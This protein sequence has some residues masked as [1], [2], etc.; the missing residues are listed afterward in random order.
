MRYLIS[1]RYVGC[2]ISLIVLQVVLLFFS[3]KNQIE[4]N[5]VETDRNAEL[6]I[7]SS[8][9]TE[10][11]YDSQ[12]A[13]PEGVLYNYSKDKSIL[14]IVK[15]S[16]IDSESAS[17]LIENEII[18]IKALYGHSLSPYPGEISNKIVYNK[19]LMPQF[20]TITSDDKVYKY[21]LLYTND[22]LGLGVADQE[23][24]TYKHLLG[25]IYL[26]E[27]KEIYIIK[28]FLSFD[29]DFQQLEELFFNMISSSE[30]K[31]S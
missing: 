17:V 22:R 12:Y 31:A 23:L 2:F 3:F 28:Y 11:T 9:L 8:Q 1:K 16:G 20:K 14:K 7:F 6:N 27:R 30:S 15:V 4:A 10:F 19:K 5:V 21:F 24:V 26:D 29:K 18:G 25:W 13:L